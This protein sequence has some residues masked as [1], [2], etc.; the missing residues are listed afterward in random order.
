MT[1]HAGPATMPRSVPAPQQHM[2]VAFLDGDAYE[3]RVRGHRVVVD[4]PVDAGGGDRAPTPTELFVGSLAACVAFYAGR[5][6]ARH[7]FD[8]S[9][10]AVLTDFDM[11]TDRPARV[12]AIRITVRPPAGFPADRLAALAAVASHCT[13][14]NSLT[15]R[16]EVTVTVA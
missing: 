10:L 2:D 15:S 8:R 9:G 11:A 4:Q 12:G 14:H 3:I 16:P 13:V 6:L 5:Y 7:G 1:E